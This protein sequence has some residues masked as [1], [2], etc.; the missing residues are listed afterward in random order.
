[1]RVD[2][3]ERDPVVLGEHRDRELL[4]VPGLERHELAVRDVVDAGAGVG[5]EQLADA[6]VVV[7][8]ALLVH[9]VDDVERLA[10]APVLADVVEALLHGP[11]PADRDVVRRHQPADAVLGVAEQRHG[12]AALVR[13]Q[14]V[15]KL[16]RRGRRQLLQERRAVVRRHLVQDARDAVPPERLQQ[17][18]LGLG[19]EVL[20]D[21][22]GLV[23]RQETERDRA[24][25]LLHRLDDGGEFDRLRGA[26]RFLER[27]E[28]P[29]VQRFHDL[30]T[31]DRLGHDDAPPGGPRNDTVPPR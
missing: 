23:V 25:L 18:L 30:G 21:V 9:D 22:R 29:R 6:E 11:A 19:L 20:E 3:R 1:M 10:V 7:Q 2:D 4:V 5:H 31:L 28:V 24:V 12:D 17:P 14:E 27:G 8:P 16:P 26:E 15:Q 13:S